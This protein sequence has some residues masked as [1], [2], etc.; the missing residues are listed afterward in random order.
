M[1]SD[2][3]TP[4]SKTS[5]AAAVTPPDGTPTD[6]VRLVN[7]MSETI[8]FFV[9]ILDEDGDD[10]ELLMRGIELLLK[11]HWQVRKWG[12]L[13]LFSA[14]DVKDY[15]VEANG[16][17]KEFLSPVIIKKI[18]CIVEFAQYGDFS[19]ETTLD[20]IMSRLAASKR[21][22]SFYP[23]GN[24]SVDSPSRKKSVSVYDITG[25]PTLEKFS[26]LDEDFFAWK[27]KTEDQMGVAGYSRFLTDATLPGNHVSISD[28]VFHSLRGAL[29]E[30]QAHYMAQ[31][32]VDEGRLN[33]V[34]LW[35]Q[36]EKYYD[37][38]LNRANVVLFDVRRLLNFRL[39]TDITASKFI[40]DFRMCLQR[41]RANKAKIAEDTDAL[42]AFLLVAIQDEAFDSVRESIVRRPDSDIETILNELREREMTLTIT[43][44]ASIGGDGATGTRYSRRVQPTSVSG[45]TSGGS[46]SVKSN[47][48]GGG[49]DS[50]AAY[51]KWS[52]PKLPES[53]RSGFG[54]SIYKTL[55]AWRA[56]AHR[57]KTQA[58]LFAEY[59]IVT[60]KYKVGKH[61]SKSGSGSNSKKRP[62]SDPSS[63]G[64]SGQRHKDGGEEQSG[65]DEYRTRVRLQ[66]SRRVITE[67]SA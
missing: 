57:G 19:V 38:S 10:R 61:S 32:L 15:I 52:V 46:D 42:R 17:A 24:S 47:S 41:L 18:G 55:L 8:E 2:L 5:G 62:S 35:S 66:K 22:A 53:W 25:I 37:T 12:D 44:S 39:T 33:P 4:S 54:N 56:D 50:S 67:R 45:G 60:E 59:T 36:L 20:D 63:G 1:S 40:T 65:N 28:G 13:K 27:A 29:R 9:K 64:D 34:S 11:E 23:S 49:K 6:P 21:R 26:G 30:G 14:D 7:S 58:Q 31:A 16:F 43:E 51:T 48:Q 3:S